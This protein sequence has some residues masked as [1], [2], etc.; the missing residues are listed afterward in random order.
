MGQIKLQSRPLIGLV[1]KPP[2][3]LL[4][5]PEI[6]IGTAWRRLIKFQ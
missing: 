1:N 3:E 5:T 4:E 2:F 6:E